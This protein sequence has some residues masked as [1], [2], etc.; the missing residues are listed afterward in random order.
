MENVRLNQVLVS[1]C[2][3]AY[4]C[5][6]YIEAAIKSVLSQTYAHLELIVV[7]DGSTDE[8]QIVIEKYINDSRVKLINQNN[9]GA[10]KARNVAFSNAKGK[11][12]KFLDGDDVIS[13]EM[14][15]VQVRSGEKNQDCIISSK[16]GRFFND[17]YISVKINQDNL[18][19]ITDGRLWL[20]ESWKDGRSMTQP[21]IFLIPKHIVQKS[22][23]WDEE[24]TLIDDLDFFTRVIL[25]SKNVVFEEDALLY[26][27]SGIN[28]SLSN[29]KSPEA[30]LSAY[31]SIDKATGY[32][33]NAIT[34]KDAKEACANVWQGFIYSFYPQ[35][36]ELI[37][38]AE[39]KIESLNGSTI[40]YEGGR[41]TKIFA[42]FFGWKL[43]QRLK[44]FFKNN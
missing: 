41:I 13:N 8:T 35:C 10:S 33:L 37:F 27:R 3:P 4:N 38:K 9:S 28:L 40:S 24:L 31:K 2:M 36:P 18:K 29:R 23:L 32:L 21:G 15:E 19:K 16:W 1:I 25:N 6:N 30:I 44:F 43:I 17:D 11:Y 5:A 22:G 34:D 14:V 42:N 39:K 7:N 20:I 12:I 26:Y